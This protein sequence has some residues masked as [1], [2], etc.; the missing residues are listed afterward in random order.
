[1][2]VA[3]SASFCT[4]AKEDAGTCFYFN[5]TLKCLIPLRLMTRDSDRV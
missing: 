5:T 2:L 1:M 3:S 4:F